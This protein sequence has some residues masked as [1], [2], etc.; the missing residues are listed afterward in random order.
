MV[1]SSA[2]ESK[3][4]KKKKSHN[5]ITRRKIV[6]SVRREILVIFDGFNEIK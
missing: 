4:K 3:G 1:Y 6:L 2:A 5:F